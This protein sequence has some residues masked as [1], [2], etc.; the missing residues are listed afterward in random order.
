MSRTESLSAEGA[1]PSADVPSVRVWDPVVRLFHWTVMTGC[2]LNLFIL[3]EGKYWHRMTGYVVAGAIVVRLIWGFA[4]TPYARFT[5]FFPTP[6]KVRDHIEALLQGRD[7]RTLG[8]SPLGSV[9]MIT[10]MALLAAVCL[11][12]WMTTID[13]FW[14]EKWLETLHG[15][16]GNMIMVL[17]FVHAA[18]AL[19]ESWRHGENLVWSM[20]PGRKRL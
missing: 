13:A 19:V 2:V 15:L 16:I 10:L 20:V 17:A 9:M 11:T 5:Q 4:G 18:S 3:D 8:H 1:S 12:G 7:E 14:G 6:R